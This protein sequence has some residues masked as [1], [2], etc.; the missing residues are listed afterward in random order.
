MRQILLA[1]TFILFLSISLFS[2]EKALKTFD[3]SIVNN[4]QS[5]AYINNKTFSFKTDLTKYAQSSKYESRIRSMT[6]M[7]AVGGGL[8]G[9][10]QV[11]FYTGVG[12]YVGGLVHAENQGYSVWSADYSEESEGLGIQAMTFTGLGLVVVGIFTVLAS[13]PLLIVG[14]AVRMYYKNRVSFYMENNYD[15]NYCST[16]IK[17]KI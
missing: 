17:I 13:L 15:K 8:L 3:D 5:S 12:L 14:L 7:A 10:S 2:N 11:L 6:I 4:S 9:L 16:G 1:L